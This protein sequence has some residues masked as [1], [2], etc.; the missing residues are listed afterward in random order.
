MKMASQPCVVASA[1]ETQCRATL[2]RALYNT[3]KTTIPHCT[4][5]V[6]HCNQPSRTIAAIGVIVPATST[7]IIVWSS[8]CIRFFHSACHGIEW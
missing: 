2:V 8:F 6:D 1:T 3:P 5:S 7:V 4:P